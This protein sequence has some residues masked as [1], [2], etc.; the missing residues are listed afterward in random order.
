MT[1]QAAEREAIQAVV[2]RVT[3]WQHGATEGTVEAELR[4][5]LDEA[6]VTLDD[7]DVRALVEAIEADGGPVDVEADTDVP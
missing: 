5:G 3:A 2:D 6:G 4:K 7:G 1:D